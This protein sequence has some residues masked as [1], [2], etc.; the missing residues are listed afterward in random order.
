MD[1]DYSSND[2]QLLIENN[3][4]SPNLV[5]SSS[6]PTLELHSQFNNWKYQHSKSYN[7]RQEHAHR[8]LIWLMNHEY[9]ERHNSNQNN[10]SSSGSSNNSIQRDGGTSTGG[11]VLAHNAYS[12]MTHL[13]FQQRFNLG[14]YSPGVVYQR[15]KQKSRSVD[16][17]STTTTTSRMMRASKNTGENEIKAEAVEEEGNEDEATVVDVPEYKNWVEEG[18][19]TNVKNQW[20][21]GA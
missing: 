12:D 18:A 3:N 5:L 14:E 19:V 9:I 6:F 2:I 7:T 1:N 13:E 11:Y 16:R 15:E 8:K 10:G 21:C 17:M 20:F 4:Y